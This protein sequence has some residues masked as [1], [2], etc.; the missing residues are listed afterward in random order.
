MK[1]FKFEVIKNMPYP[2]LHILIKNKCLH[3][4]VENAYQD[5]IKNPYKYYRLQYL[6]LLTAFSW[7]QSKEGS[8]FWL[9]INNQ[10]K[11]I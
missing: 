4:F 3:A 9:N 10:Q 7:E 2:L 5:A 11:I 1:T 8:E 6:D